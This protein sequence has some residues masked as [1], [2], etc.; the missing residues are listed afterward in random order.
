MSLAILLVGIAWIALSIFF[1]VKYDHLISKNAIIRN[2]VEFIMLLV[3]PI[4]G[5]QFA[6][7]L[8]N[9]IQKERTREEIVSCN[10]NIDTDVLKCNG[11][12]YKRK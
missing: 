11:I 2:V 12:E 6:V 1:L 7:E 5:M 10:M 9:D 4:L 3:I 8:I